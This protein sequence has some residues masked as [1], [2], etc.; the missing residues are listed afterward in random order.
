MEESDLGVVGRSRKSQHE[1]QIL[2]E[3]APSKTHSFVF[4]EVFSPSWVLISLV[5]YGWAKRNFLR[6]REEGRFCLLMVA[7]MMMRLSL[8]AGGP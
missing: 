1:V 6:G 3:L 2:S 4:Q 8:W 7:K 5:E